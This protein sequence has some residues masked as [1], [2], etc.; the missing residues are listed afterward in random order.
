MCAVPAPGRRWTAGLR[1]EESTVR[2]DLGTRMGAMPAHAR[3]G[4]R[5]AL[6]E[7][8]R[9]TAGRRVRLGSDDSI[10]SAAPTLV[11]DGRIAVD[12]AAEGTLDPENLSFGCAWSNV[13]QPRTM[14]GL[15]AKGRLILAT[16]DGR[17]PGVS[18]GF[19][20]EEAARLMR[21]PGRRPGPQPGRRRLHRHGRERQARQHHLRRDGRTRGGRHGAGT[22]VAGTLPSPLSVQ[23]TPVG[24][25]HTF[26]PECHGSGWKCRRS[27]ELRAMLESRNTRGGGG[28]DHERR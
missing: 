28:G 11:K 6:E 27:S 4:E 20:L 21:S 24:D 7:V 1:N 16:V 18:E 15:D 13:R 5:I 14:A 19:T 10:A 2:R 25:I 22:A 12:A 3:R 9:D 8:V 26:R 17:Q 23:L